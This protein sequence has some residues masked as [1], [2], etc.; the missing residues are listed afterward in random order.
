MVAFLKANPK[1]ASMYQ[2]IVPAMEGP[3]VNKTVKQLEKVPGIGSGIGS[4]IRESI[5]QH[6]TVFS[7][8]FQ[9][10]VDIGKSITRASQAGASRPIARG[11]KD[12]FQGQRLEKYFA[13]TGQVPSNWLSKWYNIVYKARGDRRKFVR[14]FIVANNLLDFFGLPSLEAFD[15]KFE[16]D[17]KFR[18]QAMKNPAFADAVQQSTTPEDIA[19]IEGKNNGVG[20]AVQGVMGLKLIKMLAQGIV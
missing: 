7:R 10:P 5:S 19:A 1:A 14:N 6:K 11:V 3:L 8:L 15:D 18:E 17:A 16:N 13:R 20:D 9:K 2:K 4:R 12:Y